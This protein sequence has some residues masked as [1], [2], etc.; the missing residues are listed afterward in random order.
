MIIIKIQVIMIMKMRRPK[1]NNLKRQIRF[2]C[3]FKDHKKI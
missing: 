1:N 3:K 2:I